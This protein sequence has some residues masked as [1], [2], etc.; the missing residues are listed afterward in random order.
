[1]NSTQD[2]Y[3]IHQSHILGDMTDIRDLHDYILDD[4][5]VMELF[6]DAIS[7]RPRKKRE[8]AILNLIWYIRALG[9]MAGFREGIKRYGNAIKSR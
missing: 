9:L 1:M 2:E 3:L 7:I 5:V 8:K 6:R 4:E